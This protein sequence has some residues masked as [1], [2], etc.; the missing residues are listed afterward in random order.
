MVMICWPAGGIAEETRREEESEQV[1]SGQME[2]DRLV[3][4][5]ITG[6]SPQSDRAKTGSRKRRSR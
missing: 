1:G 6:A 2:R 5:R 3:G 4:R